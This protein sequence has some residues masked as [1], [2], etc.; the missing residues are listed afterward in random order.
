M[1]VPVLLAAGCM[2]CLVI[3]TA[4]ED[5]NQAAAAIFLVAMFHFIDRA[6]REK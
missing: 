1:R 6:G 5:T 2:L 3:E 4:M